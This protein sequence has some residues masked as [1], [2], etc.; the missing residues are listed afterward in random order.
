MV[1][2]SVLRFFHKSQLPHHRAHCTALLTTRARLTTQAL[3]PL[4]LLYTGIVHYV[5]ETTSMVEAQRT[6]SGVQFL[7]LCYVGLG[8]AFGGLMYRP[9]QISDFFRFLSCV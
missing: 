4:L 6:G 9:D 7:V 2:R 8:V 5:D 1:R 3:F